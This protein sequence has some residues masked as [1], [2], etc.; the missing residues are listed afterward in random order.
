MFFSMKIV[1]MY[2]KVVAVV[3]QTTGIDEYSMF[4]SNK[5]VCVDARSILVNVLTERGITEGEISYLTGLTQQCV[6]KLKNNFSIRTRKGV[7][8]QIYNQFTTS[9][10]RYNLST[11]D[12]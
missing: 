9:L 12:L 11:T 1:D 7:S 6:N 4:H 5:E 2:Q 10:Q 3:C 8:Q